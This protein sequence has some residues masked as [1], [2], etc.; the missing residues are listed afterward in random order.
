MGNQ[1]LVLKVGTQ[2]GLLPATSPGEEKDPPCELQC[3]SKNQVT[4]GTKPSESIWIPPIVYWI[5]S[6]T[7]SLPCRRNRYAG[8]SVCCAG[9]ITGSQ[10][11]IRQAITSRLCFIFRF[12]KGVRPY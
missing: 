4:A 6:I 12:F 5:R 7:G 9:F 2:E 1:S 3:L 11:S 8:N 10:I